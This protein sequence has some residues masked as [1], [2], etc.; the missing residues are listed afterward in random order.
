MY[1][2][3]TRGLA[4]KGILLPLSEL[5]AAVTDHDKDYYRSIFHYTEAHY[6]DFKKTHTIAGIVDV[7][8]NMLVFDFDSKS[9]LEQARKDTIELCSRLISHGLVPEQF[10]IAFSGNKGMSVE[11]ETVHTFNP[12]QVKN[13][14]LNLGQ[15]LATLDDKIYNAS[16]VF[17]VPYTRHQETRNFNPEQC[18]AYKGPCSK[19]D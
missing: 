11:M 1:A 12:T 5:A 6:Q 4:D 18:R 16:R 8:T 7:T 15:G 19:S 13:I 3:L 2:R 14:A 17:R 9:N 10:N